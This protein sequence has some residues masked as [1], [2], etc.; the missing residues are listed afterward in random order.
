M[1]DAKNLVDHFY[2]LFA[3]GKIAETVALFSPDCI[4]LTP[5]GPLNQ[6]QHADMGHGFKAAFPDSHMSVD[7]VIE[8]G[9]EVVVMGHFVGT[10][11][12]DLQGS[13]GT[14]PASGGPLNLRFIDYFKVQDGLFVDQQTIFDQMEL[15]GQVG[16]LPGS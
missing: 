6:D 12:G 11:T 2:E 7:H 10:H 16:A 8:S 15:L 9:E 5:N 14:I 3:A 1:G 4:T 13:G